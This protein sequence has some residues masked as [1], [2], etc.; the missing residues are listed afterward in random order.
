MTLI[1]REYDRY[2]NWRDL[3][4]A[5]LLNSGRF[6]RHAT[7]PEKQ[8]DIDIF[9]LKKDGDGS[10]T[11]IEAGY[12]EDRLFYLNIH[13]P[14]IPGYIRFQEGEYFRQYDFIEGKRDGIPGL[15]FN[16]RNVQAILDEFKRGLQ[17]RELHYL[18]NG[19][20]EMVRLYPFPERPDMSFTYELEKAGL[21]RRMKNGFSRLWGKVQV[22]EIK[23]NDIFSGI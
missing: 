6:E 20:V 13:N 11:R 4:Q 15:E 1:Q 18:R 2:E 10:P 22:R 7:T 16:E 3:I 17:G 23:L 5:T 12:L 14:M 21:Y 19:K 8:K 9:I